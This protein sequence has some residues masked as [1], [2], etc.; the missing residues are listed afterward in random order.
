MK[1]ILF[2]IVALLSVIGAQAQTKWD[3]TQT[4]ASDVAA[5]SAATSEWAYTESSNRYESKVAFDG[6]LTAGGS[7]LQMTKGLGFKAAE[8]KIRIDVDNRLQLAGKNIT[9]TTPA[10]KKGQG[11]IIVFASTGDNAVTFDDNTNL[12]GAEG[13]EAAD[14]NTRQTGTATVA[15]DGVVTFKSTGGSINIYSIEV[16]EAPAGPVDQD[17]TDNAVSRNQHQNQALLTL[18]SGDINYYNTDALKAIDIND[19]TGLVTVTTKSGGQ[20][21]Y[22]ATVAGISFAKK[23]DTG[24][25]PVIVNGAVTI[26]ESQ[27]WLESL[28]VKWDL[29]D[30]VKN[31]NSSST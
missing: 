15:E 25:D 18:T 2:T 4:P 28:Y 6:P 29:L 12:T 7:E 21:L 19:E 24:Q 26:M 10:L 14:K 22:H 17:V 3:F 20:D 9:V 8:K 31:S 23:Q 27:G 16:T 30:G 13:F 11:V 1:K 5:L